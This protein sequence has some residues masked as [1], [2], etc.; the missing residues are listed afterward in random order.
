MKI[1]AA[2]II[3]AL[4]A[5][6]HAGAVTSKKKDAEEA[7]WLVGEGVWGTATAA[8]AGDA[9]DTSVLSYGVTD[10]GRVYLYLMGEDSNDMEFALTIS[11]AALPPTKNFAK[12]ACGKLG[13]LD[14]EDPRCAK[15]TLTGTTKA[16][17]VDKSTYDEACSKGWDALVDKH[18]SMAQWPDD[19]QFVVYELQPSD[20]WMIA[21]FGGGSVID[22]EDFRSAKPKHH[23]FEWIE[24]SDFSGAHIESDADAASP[25]KVEV[26]DSKKK[27]ERS[28]W[29]VAK[30]LWATIST[31]SVRLGGSKW[32]NIRSIVDG[33]SLADCTGLPHFYLPTPDPTN[34]D[35]EA[36]PE[37]AIT[38]SEAA[39][40]DRLNAKDQT[41]CDGLD[42]EH[43]LC[44][45]VV[46]YGTAVPVT[47][48]AVLAKIEG[49]FGARHPFAPW[50]AKG[51]SHT[52]GQYFT[53]D[54]EKVT[55]LDYYGGAN[56]VDVEE[57]LN[58]SS[59]QTR[60]LKLR[61]AH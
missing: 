13:I 49:D 61:G 21:S 20:I 16:C 48:V 30:S 17:P 32:G 24:E 60:S 52:G 31:T 23:P 7:R 34:V 8:A 4:A 25:K 11:E 43:P 51:G 2:S 55:I 35:V 45:R 41:I 6:I 10:E 28:R 42:P 1:F 57:Y 19:H 38:M 40:A 39:L 50:L 59:P 22:P 56:V 12:A 33:S 18:P 26:P 58:W 44:A 54:L 27:V 9:L 5:T 14:P 53:I 36:N 15:I 29:V 3:M 46:L 37:I 47:D